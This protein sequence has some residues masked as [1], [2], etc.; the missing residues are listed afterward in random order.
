M[1]LV[2]TEQVLLVVDKV[3]FIYE[4]NVALVTAIRCILKPCS[5]DIRTLSSLLNFLPP[6]PLPLPRPFTNVPCASDLRSASTSSG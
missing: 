3:T 2:R 1:D 4:H 6:P 5:L